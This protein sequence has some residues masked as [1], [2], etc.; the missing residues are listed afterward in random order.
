[1]ERLDIFRTETLDRLDPIDKKS[2]AAANAAMDE[3][4]ETT[5]G[6][7]NFAIPDLLITNT[8]SALYVY[9]NATVC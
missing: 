2:Q 9:L 1:M 3:L 6:V 5:V 8:R 4:L 7:D